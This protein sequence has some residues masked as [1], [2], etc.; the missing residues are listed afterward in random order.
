MKILKTV[1]KFLALLLIVGVAALALAI[2][3]DSDC[4]EP[5]AT[6]QGDETFEAVTFACYG[7][8]EVM[9]VSALAKPVPAA[10]EVV[11]RVR[12]A[13]VNPLDWHYMRG[14]PYIMRLS[15]G[16]GAPSD[17][18]MGVDFAGTVVAVGADVTR[19][20]S[21]DAVFGGANGSFAEYVTIRET[22]AIALKPDNISFAQAGTV[23][24]AGITAL[25]ALVDKGALREGQKVL[26]NGASGGVGTFAVQLAVAMGAE[27]TGVSSQRNHALLRN[28]G[29]SHAIDYK[30]ESYVESGKVYDLVIDMIGNHSPLAISKVLT[31]EGRLIIVGGES[32]D[33]IGPLK[34]PLRAMAQGPFMDQEVVVLMASLSYDGMNRLADFMRE[35]QLTPAVG[36]TFSLGE[37]A[38]AIGLSES[39]RAQGK[40][41]VSIWAGE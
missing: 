28:L 5:M 3:Y 30:Q 4:P 24:I 34:G 32:G 25:Q 6:A 19:F 41:A 23:G 29:A 40:I 31:P 2:S 1:F 20:K 18:R 35:G 16:I 21:G 39:G 37:I 36:H 17:H 10:N 26:V 38:E 12:S 7:G 11:V 27:V 8:T 13:G 9:Q 33:W 22:S 15:S 14:S